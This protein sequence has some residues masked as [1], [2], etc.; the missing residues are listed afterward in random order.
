MTRHVI[1]T[2]AGELGLSIHPADHKGDFKVVLDT[3]SL[4]K[5]KLMQ[6]V[7]TQG[8]GRIGSK[9]PVFLT[10]SCSDIEPIVN[11]LQNKTSSLAA[12]AA[13][14]NLSEIIE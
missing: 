2:P 5:F 3:Q 10:I 11:D 9:E 4:D 12:W 14:H 6:F 7:A 13:N 8:I 1:D